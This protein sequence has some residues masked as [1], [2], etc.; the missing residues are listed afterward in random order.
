MGHAAFDRIAPE[1]AIGTVKGVEAHVV[2]PLEIDPDGNQ[3]LR[4]Q[5]EY[6]AG[7]E[8]FGAIVGKAQVFVLAEVFFGAAGI[9]LGPG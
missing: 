8:T 3:F 7:A 2:G 9:G 4:T 5:V 6:L 1:V